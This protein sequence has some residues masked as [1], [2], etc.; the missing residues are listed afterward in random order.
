MVRWAALCLA[1]VATEPVG[2]IGSEV[3]KTWRIVNAEPIEFAWR[4]RSLL[5]FSDISCSVPIPAVVNQTGE[6]FAT[7]ESEMTGA[8]YVFNVRSPRGWESEAHCGAKECHVGF[9]WYNALDEPARCIVAGQGETGLHAESIMLQHQA[10]SGDWVDV[11]TWGSLEGGSSVL[12]LS[13]PEVPKFQ[14]GTISNCRKSSERSQECEVHCDEGFGTVEPRL[15]CIHGAWYLPE[16]LAVGS[17]V[18]IVATAPEMMKPYWVVLDAALFSDTGCNDAIATEGEA[19]SSGEYVIKYA[20]YHPRNVW[21]GDVQT[22]WASKEPCTPGSCYFGFR[23]R[24][25]PPAVRC[26]RV[27]H[28]EGELARF[29]TKRSRTVQPPEQKKN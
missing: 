11:A 28:P 4:L 9:S 29:R 19:I 1:G 18:R 15:R 23:F 6:A 24:K 25:P 27:D 12:S 16:C 10:A 7:A 13:C 5:F 14:R 8:E 17:M 22:S 20:N 2:V 26:V 21:D 3:P